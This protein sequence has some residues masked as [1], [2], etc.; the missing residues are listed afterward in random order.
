MCVVVVGQVEEFCAQETKMTQK[1]TK[2]WGWGGLVAD[3]DATL[4]QEGE[5]KWKKGTQHQRG[6]GVNGG[7]QET[8]LKRGHIGPVKFWPD[9][10]CALQG[11]GLSK[12]RVGRRGSA[13]GDG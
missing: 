3:K 2:T 8:Q 10:I 6:G 7:R 13:D 1:K 12:A 11:E 9:R 4:S 5:G